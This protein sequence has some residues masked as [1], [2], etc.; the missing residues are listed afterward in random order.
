MA[1]VASDSNEM[2]DVQ[3]GDVREQQENVRRPKLLFLARS[4]PPVRGT[5][6]V[7]TWNIAKYLARLGW[8]VTV[9]TPLPS[10]WR[11]VDDPAPVSIQLEKEGIHRIQSDHSQRFLEPE[12]LTCRNRGLAWVF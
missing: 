3:S 4:F 1:G 7:R 5:A 8:D 6:R 12:V 10:V 11:N 9:V 2:I